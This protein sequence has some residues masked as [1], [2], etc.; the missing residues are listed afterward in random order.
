MAIAEAADHAAEPDMPMP[1]DVGD[2]PDSV[3]RRCAGL[4]VH[5]FG[6]RASEVASRQ[7]AVNLKAR[8]ME[9][10]AVW[11]RIAAVIEADYRPRPSRRAARTLDGGATAAD[12]LRTWSRSALGRIKQAVGF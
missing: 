5:F 11:N 9:Q 3:I 8:D 2:V 4:V 7:I 6:A 10:L 1:P 12:L